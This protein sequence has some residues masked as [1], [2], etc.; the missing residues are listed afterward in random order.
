[1]EWKAASRLFHAFTGRK[2]VEKLAN[3][4]GA[5]YIP[6][7]VRSTESLTADSSAGRI[8]DFLSAPKSLLCKK[9]LTDWASAFLGESH[10]L[11]KCL[12]ERFSIM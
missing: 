1:M 10:P 11:K 4:I 8:A 12:T 9:N 3:A 5:R 2:N 6:S 7:I